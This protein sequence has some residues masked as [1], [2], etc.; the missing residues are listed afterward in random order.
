MTRKILDTG[1]KI[2]YKLPESKEWEDA[3]VMGHAG[4][5]TWKNKWWFNDQNLNGNVCISVNFE[6]LL[7]KYCEEEVL[8]SPVANQPYDVMEAKL[9]ELD[10]LRRHNTF[11]EVE[12][13]DQHRLDESK[14]SF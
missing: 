11:V 6:N 5:A 12:D 2:K 3:Q 10:N 1:S 7:W 8:M 4:K 14:T 9:K 13:E